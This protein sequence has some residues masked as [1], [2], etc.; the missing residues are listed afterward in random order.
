MKRYATQY[1]VNRDVT[2]G[3][4][5]LRKKICLL[6]CSYDPHKNQILNYLVEVGKNID[7]F[8][9]DYGY[10]FLLGDFSIESSEQPMKDFCLIYKSITKK[11]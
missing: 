6:G 5:V 4:L 10:L 7:V 11:P 3:G 8:S 1:R 2:G 9:S